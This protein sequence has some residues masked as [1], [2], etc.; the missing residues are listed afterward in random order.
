M[1]HRTLT[2]QSTIQYLSKEAAV[3]SADAGANSAII[4]V[5]RHFGI[6]QAEDAT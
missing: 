6:S 2:C 5:P 1:E 3:A 4:V